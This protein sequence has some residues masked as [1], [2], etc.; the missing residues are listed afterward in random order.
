M[1][2]LILLMT[3]HEKDDT[4]GHLPFLFPL[5]RVSLALNPL[6][7]WNDTCWQRSQHAVSSLLDT[8]RPVTNWPEQSELR[9]PQSSHTRRTDG[10]TNFPHHSLNHCVW[11]ARPGSQER[12]A[13]PRDEN[14]AALSHLMKAPL[15]AASS[16]GRR[17]PWVPHHTSRAAPPLPVEPGSSL[18]PAAGLSRWH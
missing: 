14:H 3:G 11:E 16:T 4:N 9:L 5:N 10:K 15:E 2:V 18:S 8:W 6:F 12:Q 17:V 1:T 7:K 13:K